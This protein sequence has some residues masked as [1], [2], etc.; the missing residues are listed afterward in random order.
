MFIGSS[1]KQTRC[2]HGFRA[3]TGVSGEKQS[4]CTQCNLWSE[5]LEID[6]FLLTWVRAMNHPQA[7]AIIVHT[8]TN[9]PKQ[10]QEEP[11]EQEENAP[12]R[13]EEWVNRKKNNA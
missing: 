8:L 5:E 7:R 1:E 3:Y 12:I 4:K 2:G 10:Q 9:P 13:F 6:D 11:I